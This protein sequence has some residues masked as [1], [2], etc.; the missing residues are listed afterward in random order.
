LR[1]ERRD[2]SF[3]ALDGA[4]ELFDLSVAKWSGG[5]AA[6]VSITYDAPWGTHDDH[7]LA[8][9]AVISRGLRMDIEM[10]TWI[11]TQPRWTHLLNTYHRELVPNGVGFFG[12]GHTHALHDTMSYQDAFASFRTC[13]EYMR[14]WGFN[15]RAYAYPGSSGRLASTQRAN[16]DAGFMCAR[17]STVDPSTW[18]LL[19]GDAP[20]SP[21]WQYLPAVPI[22]NGS[23]RYIQSH[24]E[25]APVLEQAV[26][27]GAWVIL[28]YHAIGIPEGW[29]YYPYADFIADMDKIAAGDF[30]SANLDQAAAYVR[31]RA[32]LTVDLQVAPD[33]AGAYW[34]SFDDGLPD[35]IFSEPLTTTFHFSGLSPSRLRVEPC[36]GS[37]E[38]VDVQGNSVRV[39]LCP[40]ATP[41]LMFLE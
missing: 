29:G 37:G 4:R 16:R 10:V 15:P 9:D 36:V 21:N 12:H 35:E 20:E 27:L 23:Y 18:H 39:S 31:E 3:V 40:S 22:G 5:R 17:G 33:E 19:A 25:L 14:T 32:A 41:V 30:W 8:T 26:D 28:M 1:V 11:F 6:A 38:Y 2:Q 13:F 24:Q 7:R 34:L